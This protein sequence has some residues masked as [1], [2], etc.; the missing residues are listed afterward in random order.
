MPMF[1]VCLLCL[2]WLVWIL[3]RKVKEVGKDVRMMQIKL[4]ET[5]LEL[6][7]ISFKTQKVDFKNT[8]T[9]RK[10][11]EL[12]SVRMMNILDG[13][14]KTIDRIDELE[15]AFDLERRITRTKIIAFDKSLNA[16]NKKLINLIRTLSGRI[17]TSS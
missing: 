10:L 7:K 8:K 9:I 5:E 2:C 16:T 13:C 12:F 3:E 14:L 15:N 4:L 17:E 1:W 11:E 6:F